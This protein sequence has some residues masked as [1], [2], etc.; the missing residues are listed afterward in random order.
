MTTY[1]IP[2]GVVSLPEGDYF[3]T[4]ARVDRRPAGRERLNGHGRQI[5]PRL[6]PVVNAR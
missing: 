2:F 4:E 1:R 6:V 5:R 3:E